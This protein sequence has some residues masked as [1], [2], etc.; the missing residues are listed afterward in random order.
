MHIKTLFIEQIIE[1]SF[2]VHRRA[3]ECTMALDV[4]NKLNSGFAVPNLMTTSHLSLGVFKG[5]LDVNKASVA[6]HS[7]GGAS[8][9]AALAKDKRFKYVMLSAMF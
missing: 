6:G 1:F 2:Q 5:I 7:F 3:K 8:V 4:L 9:I